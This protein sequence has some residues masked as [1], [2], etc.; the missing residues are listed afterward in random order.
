MMIKVNTVI[1]GLVL[2]F[3]NRKDLGGKLI[4]LAKLPSSHLSLQNG[5]KS[6][7]SFQ[8]YIEVDEKKYGAEIVLPA[9]YPFS[10]CSIENIFLLTKDNTNTAI[11]PEKSKVFLKV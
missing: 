2:K 1:A 9:S 7:Y 8:I 5:L 10:P 3:G 6:S 11:N 4:S